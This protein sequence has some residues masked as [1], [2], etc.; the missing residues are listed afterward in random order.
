VNDVV[1]IGLA[2]GQGVRARP[3]TLEAPEYLRSKATMCVA[4]RALI[5]WQIMTLQ[6]QGITNFYIVANGRENRYQ[7]KDVLGY[8]EALGGSVQYSRSRMDRH[9]TGSGEA[10]LSGLEHWNLHGL[11]L[12]FPTDS[13]FD[14]DLAPLV[15]QH[16]TSGALV[17]IATVDRP[18]EEVA[19]KYGTI[20]ADAAG[21]IREFVEKPPLEAI[22][23]LAADPAR[24]P[25]STGLYLVDCARLRALAAVP[26]LAALARDQLDWGNDLLPWLVSNG[27]PVRVQP[28]AKAGDLGNLRDY[29]AVL[30]DV[31]SGGYP[32][33]LARMEPPY[34]PH[35]WIHESSLRRRDPV[36]GTTLSDKLAAGLVRIGPHAYIGRDVEIGPGVRISDA[37][38]GDGVDLHPG[39]DLRRVACLDGAV[40]GPA[41]RITDSHIGVMARVE[42]DPGS[43]TV[44]D[45]YSALGHEVTVRAG[46]RLH[47]VTVYPRLTVPAD[48]RIPVGATLTT[49]TELPT[50]VEPHRTSAA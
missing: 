25:I 8:G 38:V 40:V 37:C 48:A 49:P 13:L 20:V 16:R 19:G 21:W 12:V 9:N 1:G 45:G 44:V 11:A 29:L 39:C 3:L 4:G 31:L 42:S 18:A 36:S 10:T 5:E 15:D 14:F 32:R 43:P 24:V 34:R 17:T 46:A 26:D 33:L 47:G 27:Y 22:G 7:V 28:I 30:T 50:L 41:A 6:D 23:R 35:V 2:G